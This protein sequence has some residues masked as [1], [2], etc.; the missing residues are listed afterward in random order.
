M[1]WGVLGADFCAGFCVAFCGAWRVAFALVGALYFF[2]ISG[3]FVVA[4]LFA[5][6]CL[7]FT[8]LVG[9]GFMG[10]ILALFGFG[11]C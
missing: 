11:D 4:G 6:L 8:A 1:V 10:F 3:F 9:F 5:L 2:A 7:V